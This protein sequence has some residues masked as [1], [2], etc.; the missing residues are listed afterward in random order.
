[1]KILDKT[2]EAISPTWARQRA[3]ERLALRAL[4]KRKYEGASTSNRN[5]GWI[6]SGTSADAAAIPVLKRLRDRSRDLVRNNPWAARGVTVIQEN[7]VGRGLLAQATS[8]SKSLNDKIEAAWNDWAGSRVIDADG[9]LNLY[10]LQSLAMRTIVESGEVIVRRRLRKAADGMDVPVQVQLLE[11]DLLDDSR[12]RS[13]GQGGRI[14]GGVQY[15]SIGKVEGFWI[16]RQHP[17][18]ALHTSSSTSGFVTAENI[19]QVFRSDRPHQGRGVPW[20]APVMLR[21]RDFDDFEDAQLLRQKLAACFTAFIV[22]PEE[23]VNDDD[24]PDELTPG[25]IEALPPGRDVKFA[26]PPGVEGYGEYSKTVLHA[27]ASGLGITYEALTGDYSQVNFSSARMGWLEF[28]RNLFGWRR[29]LITQFLDPVWEWFLEAAILAG[30]LPVE[31]AGVRARWTPPRREMIDP[32]KETTAQAAAIKNGL[33]S[34]AGA[35]RENGLEPNEHLEEIA[36]TNKLLEKLG[37]KIECDTRASAAAAEPPP[38][39][40]PKPGSAA[41]PVE[42]PGDTPAAKK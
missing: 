20:L 3:A 17:G 7:T 24:L 13:L 9:R 40:P 11:P 4:S 12:D 28:S 10:G 6:T 8:K 35:L 33:Q 41:E 18:D 32:V 30:T 31:A 27:I 25:L 1:M 21:L 5:K 16:W 39:D 37:I 38:T 34:L 14:S 23:T 26:D 19:S 15:S 29:M 22:T 36:A 2:I 42:K